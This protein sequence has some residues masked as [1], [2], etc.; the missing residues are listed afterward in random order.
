MRQQSP[1]ALTV[2]VIINLLFQ[3]TAENVGSLS[4]TDST[5]SS[6]PR[7]GLVAT[8]VSSLSVTGCTFNAIQV[9]DEEISNL[10][11]KMHILHVY[12]PNIFKQTF[13]RA[14]TSDEKL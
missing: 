5:F 12:G 10:G 4:V 2:S 13:R 3:I 1:P 7:A 8:G 11:T 9:R 14:N 6:L